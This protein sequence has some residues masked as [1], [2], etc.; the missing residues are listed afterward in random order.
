MVLRIGGMFR[1]IRRLRRDFP[2]LKICIEFN[3]TGFDEIKT[4]IPRV[5]FW[6]R[7]EARQFGFADCIC[8]VSNYLRRYLLSLNPALHDRIIVNPNGVDPELFKPLGEDIRAKSRKELNIPDSAVVF[9]Y[10][11]G[12]ESF[13]RLPEVVRQMAD[14]RRR[15]LDR[16]FL[17]LIGT[18]TD[19]EAVSEAIS[20]CSA[21]L[22]R[23]IVWSNRWVEHERIPY[24]MAA[25][26]VGIF[27]YSNPYGAPQ[28]IVEYMS[29][30]LPL[31]GPDVPAVTEQFPREYLPFLATQNGSNFEQLIRHLYANHKSCRTMALRA[32]ELVKREFTWVANAARV[33][34][35]ICS[36]NE[37]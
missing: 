25:F 23:W 22:P 30:G 12:T 2:N 9:G 27:P 21:D 4:W 36:V 26:D 11:G 1:F 18:S 31:I 14:L 28:K 17:V 13:R 24:L 34:N 3:A 16:L 8:V 5:E 20:E 32:R 7:E 19:S 6:R 15:E 35:A 29:C 37:L 10:V 33:V